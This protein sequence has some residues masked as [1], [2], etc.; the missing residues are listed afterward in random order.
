MAIIAVMLL[1]ITWDANPELI[2]LFGNFSLRWYS[3]LFVTGLILGYVVVS[4]IFV[5]EGITRN[6]VDQLTLLV[7]IGT[8]FGARLGHCL[9]Y[10][11][12]YYLQ[13]PLEMILPFKFDGGIEFTGFAGLASH[14]G[15]IGVIIAIVYW[16]IRNKQPL[17]PI[18]DKVAV[19][20]P[21]VG[22]FIRL[23]NFFNSEIIG[24][25]T[26]GDYGI[27]FKKIDNVARHPG[28]LYE[29]ISYIILFVIVFLL[30]KK[31]ALRNKRGFIFGLMFAG[32]F[33]ARFVIEFSK[34]E[35]VAF[36]QGMTLNMGQWLSIP[37]IIVGLIFMF[38]PQKK[39]VTG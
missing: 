34:I 36:E 32:I 15:A 18:L 13:H 30:Y 31:D 2:N 27:I 4:K 11:P 9:F 22:F 1:Q 19:G 35:Q 26:G 23:G 24:K 14:G 10:E 38:R 3:L 33:I 20:V 28:Q 37:F 8:V 7:F 5:N 21:L 16:S 6:K 29:A 25:P 12:E 17:I 39:V